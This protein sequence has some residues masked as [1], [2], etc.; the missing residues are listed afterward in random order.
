VTERNVYRVTFDRPGGQWIVTRDGYDGVLARYGT[1]TGAVSLAQRI[2]DTYRPSRLLVHHL[3]GQLEQEMVYLGDAW[4]RVAREPQPAP[5][6]N[7]G[8]TSHWDTSD[9]LGSRS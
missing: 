9:P 3:N 4:T 5:A 1:K 7:P 2:A 6:A 8:Q